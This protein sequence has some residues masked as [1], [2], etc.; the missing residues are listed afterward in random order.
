MAVIPTAPRVEH[1]HRLQ[2]DI[3]VHHTHASGEPEVTNCGNHF[4]LQETVHER[5]RELDNPGVDPPAGGE[6]PDSSGGSDRG[7]HRGVLQQQV[8]KLDPGVHDQ[9]AAA[10]GQCSPG[11]GAAE[12]GQLGA[13][14]AETEG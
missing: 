12:G 4:Q 14:R 3:Q 8:V 6:Y 9:Y 10:G 1:I 5:I 13:E 7:V 11:A 2:S